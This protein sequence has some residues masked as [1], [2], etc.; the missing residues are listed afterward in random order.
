MNNSAPTTGSLQPNDGGLQQGRTNLQPQS[1]E[2][3]NTQSTGGLQ[4][5]VLGPE[6]FQNFEGL[7]V[8][9]TGTRGTEQTATTGQGTPEIFVGVFIVL[10]VGAV[11]IY[12]KYKK[13][14][15]LQQPLPEELT[16]V[17]ESTIE[18]VEEPTKNVKITKKQTAKKTKTT[19]K[20]PLKKKSS[21]AKKKK[22][23]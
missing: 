14:L 2:T 8:Q 10:L 4:Q 21:S 22:S 23:K 6:A 9:G 7:S 18:H 11:V 3:S 17:R 16:A 15:Q 12:K 1:T 13:V 20:K 19:H 5:D